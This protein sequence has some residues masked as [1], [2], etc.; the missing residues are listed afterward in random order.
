MVDITVNI[1]TFNLQKK[2]HFCFRYF[3]RVRG[4]PT[5]LVPFLLKESLACLYD[6]YF[7]NDDN[8]EIVTSRANNTCKYCDHD[9]DE[10]VPAVAKHAIAKW[11]YDQTYPVGGAIKQVTVNTLVNSIVYTWI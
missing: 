11:Y 1:P 5:T 2:E 10:E 4:H 8:Y 7:Q 6:K 3:N 9:P